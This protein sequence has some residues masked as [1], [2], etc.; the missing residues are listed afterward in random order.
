MAQVRE[1]SLSVGILCDNLLPKLGGCGFRVTSAVFSRVLIV[2][3][4][5][6]P[7]LVRLRGDFN[8]SGNGLVRFF[9]VSAI[10][11]WLLSFS[12]VVWCYKAALVC[13]KCSISVSL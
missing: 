8:A 3:Y 9:N 2:T 7:R 1:F 12:F 4:A 6:M 13:A 5:G 11:F 10:R